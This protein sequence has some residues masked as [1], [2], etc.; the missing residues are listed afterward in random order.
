M[1]SFLSRDDGSISY[2]RKVN[3]WI[4]NKI[5]LEFIKISIKSKR[6]SDGG[7]NLTDQSVKI[8]VCGPLN[9]QVPAT[10]VID[11]LVVHHEGTIRMLKCGVSAE[12]RVIRLNYSS[13]N[14]GSRI[15]AEFQ[16]SLLSIVHRK[17]LH[18]QRSKSRSSSS[19]KRMEDQESLKSSTLIRKLSDSVKNK[20]NY[21]FTNSIVTS[22]IVVSSILLS[23]N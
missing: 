13:G 23:S 20:I 22:S 4:R 10:D 19:S 15:D 2:Q 9:V 21:F 8:G 11:G 7:Y 18:K 16:F 1:V 6:S 14:L 3:S 5:G 17:S 12:S